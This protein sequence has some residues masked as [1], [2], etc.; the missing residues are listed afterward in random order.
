MSRIILSRYDDGQER[1]VVGWDNPLQTFFWQEFA[2]EPESWENLSDQ[3][4][5]EWD[6]MI[7]FAG[8]S[9]RELPELMDLLNH[10][11]THNHTVFNT[12]QKHEDVLIKALERHKTLEYPQSN[13]TLDFTS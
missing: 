1:V 2:Q 4:A 12:M 5:E 6:E 10:A 9:M 13:E 11:A 3:E 8:Y 7:G